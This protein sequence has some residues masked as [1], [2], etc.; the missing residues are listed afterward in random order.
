[1]RVKLIV[2][3]GSNAGKEVKIPTPKC[4]I[5]RGDECHLRPRSDA[6][7]RRHCVFF[8][9]DSRVV[10]RDL[11]SKN[12]TFVNGKKIDGDAVLKGGE[13]VRVGA[14]EFEVVLDLSLGGDKKPKVR[15][16]KD[17]AS[18]TADSQARDEDITNW[19]EEADEV[20][21]ERRMADPETRNFKIDE[22]D[23]V[24][25]ERGTDEEGEE[26]EDPNVLQDADAASGDTSIFGLAKGKKKKEFGKLPDRPDADAES[27]T[28][29]A[30]DM[31]KKFFNRR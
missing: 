9:K 22:T 24:E 11:K 21:R 30:E 13:H 2:L 28:K 19:L 15:S 31:L 16:V 4:I 3:Q 14:L 8:V 29:A 10:L 20:D 23:R 18:R 6:I 27:S 26:S 25:A 7:S 17:A 1:M 12:G 5:G